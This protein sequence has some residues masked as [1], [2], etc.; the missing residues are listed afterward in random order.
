MLKT[1]DRTAGL[2]F[3]AWGALG[4]KRRALLDRSWAGVFRRHLLEH[5]PTAELATCFSNGTGRPS[6]DAHVI[7]GVLILQQLH[8]LTDAAT[9]EALALNLGWHYALDIHD[10]G[11]AYLCEKTLRNH[12]R[13]VIDNGLD[14]LLLRGLTDELVKAF[15]V[16]TQR[17]R[18]DSTAIRSAMRIQTR[19]GTVVLTIAKFLRELARQRPEFHALVSPELVKRYVDRKGTGCFAD[20]TPS[21]SKRRLPE[22]GVDLLELIESFRSTP[23]AALPGFALLERVLREQFEVVASPESG[24]GPARIRV[25]EPKGLACDI[26]NNPSD[27]ESSYNKYRGQ[28]YLAQVMETYQEDAGDAGISGRPDLITHVTVGKMNTHDSKHLKPALDDTAERGI[29]PAMVLGDTHYGSEAN[30]NDA[31]ARGGNQGLGVEL[32]S[33]VMTAK[34]AKQGDLTLEQFT[35]DD[36]G[37]VL[38]CPAG[39]TPISTSISPA[40]LQARFDPATCDACAMKD[41]CPTRGDRN[42]GDGSRLQYTAARVRQRLR[43]LAQ[44]CDDFRGRYRWRA[45]VEAT[46]SRLKHQVGLG[47]LRVR[48]IKSVGY[49]VRLR[50]L[51]LN[52]LRCTAAQAA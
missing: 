2:L 10:E 39:H 44:D 30:V 6:K 28:G 18:L 25:I 17:Q 21:T 27:P 5:L 41:T 35:L 29:E 46:M 4:D 7:F 37:R 15:K 38:R 16:D 13:R 50:A 8:D 48:G 31:A 23:A 1:R 52:I 33:P 12:R 34:G 40:K 9:V 43:R 36:D 14:E 20:T 22:A 19:L 26:L 45:G 11:D 3:D 47:C 51:G 32:V 24:D 49:T 42:R